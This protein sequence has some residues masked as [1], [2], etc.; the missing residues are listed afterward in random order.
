MKILKTLLLIFLFGL[1]S[2]NKSNNCKEITISD[3]VENAN[4]VDLILLRNV[5][6][7][8][9]HKVNCKITPYHYMIRYNNKRYKLP[10]FDYYKEDMFENFGIKDYLDVKN[11]S[12]D[13]L[14]KESS[15]II[16]TFEKL[17]INRVWTVDSAI[18]FLIEKDKY[19]MYCENTSLIE[20]QHWREF[21]LNS[22]RKGNWYFI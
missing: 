19:L 20:N 8:P 15:R 7:N 10:N 9:R 17:N 12:L 6:I 18:L 21:L 4:K 5:T 1:I 11:I 13:S 3:V 22:K 16:K 2:C 14:K